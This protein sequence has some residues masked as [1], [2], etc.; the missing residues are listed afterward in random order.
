MA[1]GRPPFLDYFE[2]AGAYYMGKAERLSVIDLLRRCVSH[3]EGTFPE[4]YLAY[5]NAAINL[6]QSVNSGQWAYTIST[7]PSA[8]LKVS[9]AVREEHSLADT[10]AGAMFVFLPR[11]ET[12]LLVASKLLGAVLETELGWKIVK[13]Y[14]D[15][16]EVL[17]NLTERAAF[18]KL[19]DLFGGMVELVTFEHPNGT[20]LTRED[21]M[22]KFG[23]FEYP[24]FKIFSAGEVTAPA[25]ARR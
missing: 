13:R 16:C 12:T 18:E 4:E 21:V 19:L 17:P 24:A 2:V 8:K 5:W 22:L 1:R 6:V 10:I 11:A 20:S 7:Y 25:D 9:K 14:Y 15:A 3:R 23:V